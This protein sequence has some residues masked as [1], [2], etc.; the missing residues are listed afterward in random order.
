MVDVGEPALSMAVVRVVHHREAEAP[1][2]Q[3]ERPAQ[4]CVQVGIVK[5]IAPHPLVIAAHVKEVGA[6]REEDAVEMAR[7]LIGRVVAAAAQKIVPMVAASTVAAA[8]CCCF[9][10]LVVVS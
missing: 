9:G 8:A 4:P 2:A 3:V 10:R 6:T 1:T 5:A 7:I